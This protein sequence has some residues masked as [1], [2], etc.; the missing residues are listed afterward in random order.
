MV[1]TTSPYDDIAL[2]SARLFFLA[3]PASN[4]RMSL[5]GVKNRLLESKI[6][7]FGP[8]WLKMTQKWLIYRGKSVLFD[9]KWA[10]NIDFTEQSLC[11]WV[12]NNRFLWEKTNH[13]LK[14]TQNDSKWLIYKGKSVLLTQNSFKDWIRMLELKYQFL[15]QKI[16]KIIYKTFML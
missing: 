1:W 7:T 14:M 6:C 2:K 9:L 15:I 5:F 4:F 8:K 12:E 11:F 3:T 16:F 13:W 10:K